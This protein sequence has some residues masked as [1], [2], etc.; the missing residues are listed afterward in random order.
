[1]III[2]CIILLKVNIY[3]KNLK[4]SKILVDIYKKPHNQIT[5]LICKETESVFKFLNA[6]ILD[7]K[8]KYKVA[9]QH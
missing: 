1:M 8:G 3:H 6:E 2:L 7:F 9:V 5:A 4:L